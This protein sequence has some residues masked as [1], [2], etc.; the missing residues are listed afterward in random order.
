MIGPAIPAHLKNNEEDISAL[1]IAGPAIPAHLIKHLENA[2]EDDNEDAFLPSLPPDLAAPPKPPPAKQI[3]PTLPSRPPP[4]DS[5]SDDD[6]GPMPLPAGAS[7][8]TD[9]NDGVREFMERERRRQE[10]IEVCRITPRPI[11]QL[12]NQCRKRKS[13][14]H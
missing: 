12:I 11:Q 1:P 4:E 6:Y 14:K 9:E 2:E 10:N 3:G 8:S 5:D 13:P 7:S